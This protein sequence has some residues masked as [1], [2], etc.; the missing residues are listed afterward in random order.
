MKR[1]LLMYGI[2]ELG[3]LILR[4]GIGLIFVRHGFGKIIAG[5]QTWIALGGAMSN[6]GITFAPMIWGL[7]AAFAESFGG[8]FL[9]LGY[10]TRI[11]SFFM[12]FVMFVAVIMHLKKGDDWTTVSHPL[13]LL[14]VFISLMLM[15]SGRYSLDSRI[16]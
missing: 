10:Y 1:F 8:I 7:L 13:A 4:F 2:K 14:I 6:F 9:V 5:K 12:A 11:A 16:W 3:L 15:G